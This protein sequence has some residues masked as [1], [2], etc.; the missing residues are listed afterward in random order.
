MEKI[1]VS[2]LLDLIRQAGKIVISAH[3]VEAKSENVHSKVG[4]AN[5]VTVYDVKV[6]N[7]LIER[8]SALMPSAEFFAEE[9]ENAQKLSSGFTFVIDPID[10]T[11]NFIHDYRLSSISVGLLYDGEAVF[12]AVYSPY[13]DEMFTAEKG[14]GALLNGEPIKA[15]SHSFG[16]AL[17]GFGTSP[18]YKDTLSSKTFDIVKR[19]FL[20]CADIRR[21]GSAAIDLCYV[22]CGRLDGFFECILSPWDYAAGSLIITEAGGIVTKFDGTPL[23]LDEPCSVIAA[24]SKTYEEFCKIVNL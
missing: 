2:E 17:I 13:Y 16:S 8:I 18:Y 5:F 15:G 3:D 1:P 4:T 20:G 21:S 7:F 24:N 11:T 10:G 19:C 22:A 14:K 9:K 12:G 6:Q 23:S